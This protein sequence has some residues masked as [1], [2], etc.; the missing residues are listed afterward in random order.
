V[1]I[2]LPS[3]YRKGSSPAVWIYDPQSRTVALRPVTVAQFR[4]DG[5]VVAS[6]LSGGEWIVAAGV[7]KLQPGQ[8]VRPY[9]GGAGA[10]TPPTPA[11]VKS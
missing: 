2:P 9:E 10:E 6:G 1:L 5:I 11:P 8:T 7:N 4:E 3:L